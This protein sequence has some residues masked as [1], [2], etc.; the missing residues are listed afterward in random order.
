[1]KN[2]FEL[3]VALSIM[4]LSPLAAL[5]G[6]DFDAGVKLYGAKDY[7]GAKAAFERA[8]KVKANDWQAQYYLGHCYLALGQLPQSKYAY[9][10]CMHYSQ[11][12]TVKAQC[13]AGIDRIDKI[14]NPSASSATAKAAAEK[15]STPETAA[16]ADDD[17]DKPEPANTPAARNKR[18]REAIM[19]EAK[20]KVAKLRREVDERIEHEHATSNIRLR[21]PD[22]T[23]GIGLPQRLADQYHE[24]TEAECERIMNQAELRCRGLR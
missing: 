7:T 13:Q 20:A 10:L 19:E 15:S 16:K 14:R 2:R 8:V 23:R 22:G 11:D 12:A 18:E 9:Q 5:A 4:G 24:E 1:M 21:Y 3:I 17:E 6:P